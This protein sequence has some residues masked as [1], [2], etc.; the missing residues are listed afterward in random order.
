MHTLSQLQEFRDV[1]VQAAVVAG[2]IVKDGFSRQKELKY[3]DGIH[4]LVT[5]FD[6]ASERSIIDYISSCF[7]SHQFLAEESG[8]SVDASEYRWIIDPLD[9]TVNFAHGIPIFSVSIGL[10]Y[11][12]Q[13]I[14][15][16]VYQPI[17]D[18][19]F[20]AVRGQGATC[21]GKAIHVS[22]SMTLKES[23]LVTGFPYNAA[24]NAEHTLEH[25][26]ALVNMGVP[27]RRL[28][29]AAVDLAYVACG[30]FDGFW[31]S[32]LQ[33]WDVAAGLLL[34]E[35]AGGQVS[36]FDGEVFSMNDR[37]ILT[38]NGKIHREFVE[39]LNRRS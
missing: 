10:E 31:E 32:A 27:I 13:V 18:E 6:V 35:E 19:L 28:G 37:T 29:S 11:K 5:Q 3:K 17:T 24:D 23:I 36:R 2:S 30:R 20:V 25:F 8:V 14:V 21:N 7:P 16:V 1:A 22:Q 12:S 39:F 34:V 38:T 9:G 33:P 15:G 26:C 4:N